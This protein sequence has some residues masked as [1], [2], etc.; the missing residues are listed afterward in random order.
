MYYFGESWQQRN[1]FRA[2]YFEE[3]FIRFM[4]NWGILRFDLIDCCKSVKQ[5]KY[6]LRHRCQFFYIHTYRPKVSWINIVWQKNG[7][8]EDL[9]PRWRVRNPLGSLRSS[10]STG[11]LFDLVCMLRLVGKKIFLATYIKTTLFFTLA[12]TWQTHKNCVRVFKQE[13][14]DLY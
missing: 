4:F 8:L 10:L 11:R 6:I 14:V 7:R 9:M 3:S 12:A 13:L 1:V 2:I 5:G